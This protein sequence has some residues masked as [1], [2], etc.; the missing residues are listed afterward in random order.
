[1]ENAPLDTIGIALLLIKAVYDVA[2]KLIRR[3]AR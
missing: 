2:V 3:N 1:M